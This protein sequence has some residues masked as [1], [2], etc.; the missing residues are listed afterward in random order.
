MEVFGAALRLGLTSFGGPTA[1]IGYFRA[2]YVE[3]RRW[4]DDDD[5]ADLVALVQFLPGPASSQLGVAIGMLRAG[6]LGGLAAWLGF[7]LPSA[8]LL[9]AFAYGVGGSDVASDGWVH[10]LELAAVA[11]VALAVWQMARG[12]ARGL[13]RGAIAVAAAAVVLAWGG[14]LAQVLVIAGGA[15]V[16]WRLLAASARGAGAAAARLRRVAPR[17]RRRP[18]A[19]RPDCWWRCRWRAARRRATPSR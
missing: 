7:T 10:G 3:R 14:A 13:V 15:L 16:G 6:P 4:L 11:V 19:S 8:A 1:H 9:I 18:S 5:F 2:D 12:L 17:R